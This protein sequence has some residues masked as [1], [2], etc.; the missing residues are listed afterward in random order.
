MGGPWFG[1]VS[2]RYPKGPRHPCRCF[3]SSNTS[4]SE[5]RMH[6]H[7]PHAAGGHD[8]RPTRG[9]RQASLVEF[10]PIAREAMESAA[11]ISISRSIVESHGR[12]WT[13]GT[14][15]AAQ[16]FT[17]PCPPEWSSRKLLN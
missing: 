17:S 3:F 2:R 16:A 15:R 10:R 14:V 13:A 4:R 8:V 12:L 5:R 1:R 9:A 11:G 7:K 6:G